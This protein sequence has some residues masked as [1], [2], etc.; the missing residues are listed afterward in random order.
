MLEIA[1]AA[2]DQLGRCGRRAGG[3]I[4]LLQQ[5]DAEAAPSGIAGNAGAVDAA[6]DNGEVVVGHIVL[7]APALI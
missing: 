3:E 7:V 6:A 1:Q 5:E 4:A 2:V